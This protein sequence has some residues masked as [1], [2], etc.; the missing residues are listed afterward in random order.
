MKSGQN[1]DIHIDSKFVIS[2][3]NDERLLK[4][5][6][7]AIIHGQCWSCCPKLNVAASLAFEM[8]SFHSTDRIRWNY[9]DP[10]QLLMQFLF[11][12]YTSVCDKMAAKASSYNSRQHRYQTGFNKFSH[13]T[14][15]QKM[16]NYS[17]RCTKQFH[18]KSVMENE[19]K[20]LS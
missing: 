8:I 4:L 9:L 3:I 14:T 11:T 13:C 12:K 10:D 15:T 18:L 20:C 16:H 1:C 19:R 17:Q 2:P 6:T 5:S 7:P